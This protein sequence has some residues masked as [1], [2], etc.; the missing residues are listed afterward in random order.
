MFQIVVPAKEGRMEATL[1]GYWV[2]AFA[3]TTNKI[4]VIPAKAGIQNV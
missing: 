1:T 3:R 2:S 4:N